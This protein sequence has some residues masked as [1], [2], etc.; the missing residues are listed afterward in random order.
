MAK[1][2]IYSGMTDKQ[3]ENERK[4]LNNLVSKG[5]GEG[6]WAKN[7]L[8]DLDAASSSSSSSTP[9]Y[10][11]TWESGGRTYVGGVDVGPAGTRVDTSN[12]QSSINAA[13]KSNTESGSSYTQPQYDRYQQ[14][15]DDLL[16]EYQAQQDYIREQQRK[17]NEAAVNAG[18]QRLQ[19]Q[20]TASNQAFDQAGRDAYINAMRNQ[21]T[22]PNQLNA[23]GYT[24]G[25]SETEAARSRANYANTLA[26]IEQQRALTESETN[27]AINELRN[28]A[29]QRTAEQNTALAQDYIDK[30]AQLKEQSK[31]NQ[32]ADWQNTAEFLY[33][34]DYTAE[35]QRLQADNADGKNSEKIAYLM[36]LRQEKL[37]K[38][39]DDDEKEWQRKYKEAQLMAELGDYSGLEALGYDTAALRQENELKQKQAQIKIQEDEAKKI[40]GLTY[41]QLY[42]ELKDIASS[43]G[44][45]YTENLEAARLLL[46]SQNITTSEAVSLMKQFNVRPEMMVREMVSNGYPDE[47]II[48]FIELYVPET[49]QSYRDSLYKYAY[50]K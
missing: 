38:M 16:S 35:I 42:D 23:M 10:N 41:K 39:A 34:N 1:N 45:D 32:F 37:N 48:E 20:L 46:N 18:V 25:L 33:G 30:I 43:G 49:N 8:K 40:N 47:D 17:A 24:G 7:Q 28:Q 12:T 6:E 27:L 2:N 13:T 4:Y 19:N 36:A 14:E 50:N 44:A 3:K 9:S 31:A 22:L 21:Y 26:D 15:Y 5:G 11:Q 29:D